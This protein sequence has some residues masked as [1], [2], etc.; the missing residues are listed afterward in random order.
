MR[1]QS[2]KHRVLSTA[3]PSTFNLSPISTAKT[4]QNIMAP[5]FRR[6]RIGGPSQ[7]L[8]ELA[9][10]RQE[11]NARNPQND[12]AEDQT[13]YRRRQSLA[14]QRLDDH[15]IDPLFWRFVRAL[16][17]HHYRIRMVWYISLLIILLFFGLVKP[18]Y[19]VKA[20]QPAR[21]PKPKMYTGPVDT[22]A[23][24]RHPSIQYSEGFLR[25]NWSKTVIYE[26]KRPQYWK[27]SLI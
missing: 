22:P 12:D 26:K 8:E 2:G 21:I 19:W 15:Y 1:R 9:R 6:R 16:G 3:C 23:S 18:G 10:F 20:P 11:E 7:E 13:S 17:L 25:G 14:L 5:L 24:M 27:D 4:I